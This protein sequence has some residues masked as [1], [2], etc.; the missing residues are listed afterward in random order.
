MPTF[1]PKV[2][3]VLAMRKISTEEFRKREQG[4]VGG[5]YRTELY[6]KASQ[7]SFFHKVI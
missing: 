2:L 1:A 5:A 4:I 3:K 7:L 6:Q